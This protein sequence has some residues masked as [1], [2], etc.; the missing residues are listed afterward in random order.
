MR[1]DVRSYAVLTVA[2][3]V[4]LACQGAIGPQGVPG[5]PGPQG[6]AGATGAVGPTGPQGPPAPGGNNLLLWG[7]AASAWTQVS[8][9]PSTVV[10]N[11]T[12]VREGE[13]SFEFTVPSGTQGGYFT[14]GDFI[15]IDPTQV[16][17]GQLSVKLVNGAGD[18]SAGYRA[19]DKDRAQVGS[20]TYFIASNLVL[21]TGAW[22]DLT[23][24]VV[25]EGTV[26]DQF[27]VGTR[28]IKPIVAVNR[29]NI[30]TTLVDAFKIV[31]DETLRS[32]AR[33]HGYSGSA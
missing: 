14:Y 4:G 26:S 20:D 16:Y 7:G 23:G 29:N 21:T 25:G 22:T 11:T 8:G 19:F 28:F 32:I 2:L 6:A 30:G 18:F 13:S 9:A 31:P 10:A 5:E 12:D 24:L 15:A 27:P 3:A 33:W 1:D 17:R